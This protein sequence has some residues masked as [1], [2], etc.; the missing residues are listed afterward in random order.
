MLLLAIAL[1]VFFYHSVNKPYES[2]KDGEFNNQNDNNQHHKTNLFPN[3]I[4]NKMKSTQ[5]FAGK[6]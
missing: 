3:L 5:S 6:K 2:H 4:A 1:N